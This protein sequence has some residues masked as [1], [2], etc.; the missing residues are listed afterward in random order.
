[1]STPFVGT[2][3]IHL[4]GIKGVAMTSLA[5]SLHD[6]GKEISGSDVAEDFVTKE[7]LAHV[8]PEISVEFS[9]EHITKD[10]DLVIF[11][12]ANHGSNN[13]EVQQAKMLGIPTL[14][15]AEALGELMKGKRGISVCG[16]GGK[17]TTSAMISW[18]LE[19]ADMRPS[20]S[21]GVGNIQNLGR[22]GRYVSESAWYVA[23]A[24]EYAVDPE[25]DHTPRFM[26]QSPE[27]IVCTNLEYDHPD[28]YPS[29]QE[30][31][32]AYLQFF[33]KLPAN[34]VLIVNGENA[35][36]SKLATQFEQERL[37][38]K[39]PVNTIS[40]SKEHN[41]T[42]RYGGL[43]MLP[44]KTTLSFSYLG[45]N[46]TLELLLPGEFNAQ[47]AV[48]AVV[49]SVLAGASMDKAIQSM[50]QFIGTMRRFENKGV[51]KGVQYFDDYAHHP[52]EIQAT[53]SA[54]RTWYPKNKIIVIFEPHTYSR[55]KMLLD[56]FSHA[57]T[58]ADEVL[59][60]DIFASAREGKDPTISSTV[61][62]DEIW[63]TGKKAQNIHD[64]SRAVAY[65]SEKAHAGDVVMTIGA[66]DV[67]HLHE[68]IKQ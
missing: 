14:S 11:S 21:I 58:D 53:L 7:Q 17:T 27:M 31:K 44:G 55:T 19:Y 20:F 39:N 64:I 25:K 50:K 57:F 65:V 62:S 1:M 30:V 5:Q 28:I 9:A 51:K 34:G 63:A 37:E 26:L 16:V 42:V 59:L 18:I 36:L 67:Y 4:V 15:H 43:Q 10:I 33:R 66:G 52:T 38:Q 24:D 29:F 12:G 54:L 3:R 60:L 47:N 22:T 2:H 8:S 68:K 49:A 23:E 46:Q 32:D 41:A 61:L 45:E 56:E 48:Y 6:L 40:V 13:V 35:E